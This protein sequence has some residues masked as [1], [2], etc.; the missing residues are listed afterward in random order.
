MDTWE[1]NLLYLHPE[2]HVHLPSPVTIMSKSSPTSTLRPRSGQRSGQ[3]M[4][5]VGRIWTFYADGFRS[6]RT[7]RKLWI[8]ILVKLAVIF[9]I[10]K[11]FFFPDVLERDYGSDKER[12]EAVRTHLSAP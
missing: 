3:R 12:A 4:G 2:G 11:L 6:M 5:L 1:S 9:G 7:G 8:L 10:L